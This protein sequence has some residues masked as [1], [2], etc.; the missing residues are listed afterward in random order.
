MTDLI[1]APMTAS[2]TDLKKNPMETVSAGEGE[3][4]AILNRNKVVFYCVP[5]ELYGAMVEQLED[6]ELGQLADAR[7]DEERIR[8][9]INKLKAIRQIDITEEEREKIA[10]DRIK[11]KEAISPLL[12]AG[13]NFGHFCYI[14]QLE[15]PYAAPS[16]FMEWFMA[17]IERHKNYLNYVKLRQGA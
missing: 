6:L 16:P 2:I 4:I 7:K 14:P 1:H 9:D 17:E 3:P 5:A 12:D 13:M 11:L 15:F 10:E 8:V